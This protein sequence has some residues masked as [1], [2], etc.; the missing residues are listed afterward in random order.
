M[1][2]VANGLDNAALEALFKGVDQW[3][4]NQSIQTIYV[5]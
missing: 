1:W 2:R 3:M 5:N 4:P